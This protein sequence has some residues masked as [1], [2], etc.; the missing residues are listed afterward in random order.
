MREAV[1]HHSI[2]GAF[3]IRQGKW[4]LLLCAG[5]GGWSKP[6]PGAATKGLPNVQLYDLESDIAETKNLQADHPEVKQEMT[7][8]LQSYVDKGRSTPGEPQPNNGQVHI[9][10]QPAN[11]KTAKSK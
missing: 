3:S 1:V 9:T 11:R 5:S 6:R 10:K 4:K 7:A 8:L 2:N